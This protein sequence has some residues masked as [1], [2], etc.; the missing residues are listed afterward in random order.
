[1]PISVDVPG[2][3]GNRSQVEFVRSVPVP[4]GQIVICKIVENLSRTR[5]NLKRALVVSFCFG[6]AFFGIEDSGGNQ[7]RTQI[8]GISLQNE[9]GLLFSCY[10]IA[11]RESPGRFIER[12]FVTRTAG[13]RSGCH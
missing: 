12:E 10:G 4:V 7:E 8:L 1:L 9:T 6:V 2:I 13:R 11:F 3:R 5:R